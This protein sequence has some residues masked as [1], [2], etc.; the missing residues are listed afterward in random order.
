MFQADLISS[1]DTV[2]IQMSGDLDAL[3]APSFH[4]ILQQVA[5]RSPKKLCLAMH[6]LSYISSAG[7]RGLVFARQKMGDDMEVVVEGANEN[8]AET[9]RMTGLQHAIT[10]R[11]SFSA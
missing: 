7:V 10:I 9:I 4:E 5:T 11:E 2:T 3:S 1:G 6:G 8:V